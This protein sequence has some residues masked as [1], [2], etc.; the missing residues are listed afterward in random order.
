MTST[1]RTCTALALAAALLVAAPTT[2]AS[3]DPVTPGER[4]ARS[5]PAG[6]HDF[7]SSGVV[8]AGAV[9]N[10]FGPRIWG[11]RHQL[12]LTTDNGVASGYLRSFYCPSGASVSPTWASSRCTHRQTIRLQRWPGFDVGWVSS[13]GLSATQRGNL[14]GARDGRVRWPLESNLTLYATGYAMDDGDGTFYSWWREASV[15]G[16][17]AGLPILAGSRREG[18]IGGYGPA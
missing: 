6:H 4:A 10:E 1:T 17:F 3:A 18:L 14:Y 16:T 9:N 12:R 15:R 5:A 11:N 13:T 8:L 2:G 7:V